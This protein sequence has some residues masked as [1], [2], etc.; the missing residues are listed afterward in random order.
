MRR[1]ERELQ[2][3]PGVVSLEMTNG[4]HIRLTLANERMV[5]LLK[6]AERL[7]QSDRGHTLASQKGTQVGGE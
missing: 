7:R 1:W 6:Y 4:D 2:R 5:F 3:I